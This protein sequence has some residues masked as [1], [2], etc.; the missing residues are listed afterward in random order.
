[1]NTDSFINFN[2]PQRSEIQHSFSLVLEFGLG[3]IGY[4]PY[5]CFDYIER[6]DKRI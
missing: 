5:L 4:F 2:C 1:M 3:E 6:H